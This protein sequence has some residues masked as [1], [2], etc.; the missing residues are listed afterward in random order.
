[1]YLDVSPYKHILSGIHTALAAPDAVVTLTGP[2]GTGKTTLGYRLAALLQQQGRQVVFFLQPPRSPED[3]HTGILRQLHLFEKGSFAGNLGIYLQGLAPDKRILYVLIDDAEQMNAPTFNA[4]AAL[5]DLPEEQQ[6]ATRVVL[7]GSEKLE[8]ALP[9]AQDA[10]QSWQLRPLQLAQL[11]E[12]CQAW[13]QQKQL[14]P[15]AFSDRELEELLQVSGGLPGAVLAE[16]GDAEHRHEINI[17]ARLGQ[18]VADEQQAQLAQ[19]AALTHT[20]SRSFAGSLI[21]VVALLAVAALTGYWWLIP[22]DVAPNPSVAAVPQSASPPAPRPASRATPD[23]VALAR[24]N[25]PVLT[26]AT[27]ASIIAE[28]E[29]VR[30]LNGWVQNWQAQNL[31][32]YFASYGSA[33]TAESFPSRAAWEAERARIISAASNVRIGWREL[34]IRAREAERMVVEVWLDYASNTYADRT[35]KELTLGFENGRAVILRERNLTV[36]P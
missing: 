11:Q 14:A 25:A 4:L 15:G 18:V 20:G 29:V 26:P 10:V 1:M 6:I 16:L 30:L 36:Q 32:G 24:P 3:L 7:L 22:A 23:T 17:S 28:A 2:T 8:Q 35:L 27:T 5:Y 34:Q 9:A 19:Q 12:F 31:P 33:F 13:R 21:G